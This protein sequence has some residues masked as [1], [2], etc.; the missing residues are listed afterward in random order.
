VRGYFGVGVE[1]ISKSRNLGAI[2]RTTHA[3]EGSFAF[4]VNAKADADSARQTDTSGAA[5]HMPVY[6]WESIDA[7][8]L[9]KDCTLVGV[10]LCERSLHLPSFRHPE[11]AAYVLGPERGSLSPEMEALCDHVVAIPTRFCVNV[12]LACALVLYDR[13]LQSSHHPER[14][15]RAGGP[16]LSDVQGWINP[17]SERVPFTRKR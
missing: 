5:A 2:L 7:L 6:E 10:E 13:L 12:S 4:T 3:F 16:K 14:P 8:R 11:R 15:I 9:P 1:G 17:G